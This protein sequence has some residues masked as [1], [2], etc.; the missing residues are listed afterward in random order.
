MIERKVTVN[1]AMAILLEEGFTLSYSLDRMGSYMLYKTKENEYEL[2]VF[3]Q[4][5]D[6][7][8]NRTESFD[9]I[10]DGIAKFI[11]RVGKEKIGE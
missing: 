6:L 8:E 7:R 1:E 2:L 5:S 9:N 11:Q 4:R 3:N 10:G